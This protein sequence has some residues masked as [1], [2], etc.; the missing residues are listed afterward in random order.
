MDL[1]LGQLKNELQN[2]QDKIDLQKPGSR[3]FELIRLE[4]QK[5]SLEI[6]IEKIKLTEKKTRDF[7]DFER[8]KENSYKSRNPAINILFNLYIDG[9]KY[10]GN[11]KKDPFNLVLNKKGEIEKQTIRKVDK[12]EI[13]SIKAEI[14]TATERVAKIKTT[15]SE[16]K[17][18][19][20][21]VLENRSQI[22]FY[23]KQVQSLKDKLQKKQR[24]F[25]A[26]YYIPLA[27]L[28]SDESKLKIF[29]RDNYVGTKR[30]F[31]TVEENIKIL[32]DLLL[33]DKKTIKLN[34]ISEIKKPLKILTYSWRKKEFAPYGYQVSRGP[35]AMRPFL[36][37]SN[38]TWINSIEELKL[39]IQEK[40]EELKKEKITA[41]S[42]G[43]ATP[44][45]GGGGGPADPPGTPPADPP[46]G[47]PPAP[48]ADQPPGATPPE[49]NSNGE[50]VKT[51]TNAIKLPPENTEEKTKETQKTI[52]KKIRN[53]EIEIEKLLTAHDN[54]VG[55]SIVENIV[56]S[57]L[58][59]INR[60]QGRIYD[61]QSNDYYDK[62]INKN[63]LKPK[64]AL[65]KAVDN[66]YAVSVDLS[67]IGNV[68]IEADNYR[69]QLFSASSYSTRKR[70]Y[71]PYAHK[72]LAYR[73]SI[74]HTWFK[75]YSYYIFSTIPP[76]LT[77]EIKNTKL[78]IQMLSY[79]PTET[80]RNKTI[81]LIREWNK[82]EIIEDFKIV[83]SHHERHLA[84][85]KRLQ[86]DVI[87]RLDMFRPTLNYTILKT[88]LLHTTKCPKHQ[89]R[90]CLTT[91]QRI[92]LVNFNDL[93][94]IENFKTDKVNWDKKNT[95]V[96]S[97][98]EDKTTITVPTFW[99][100][101]FESINING[102]KKPLQDTYTFTIEDFDTSH[103]NDNLT[104][105]MKQ[106]DTLTTKYKTDLN[107]R[108]YLTLYHVLPS[109]CKCNF[110]KIQQLKTRE[111]YIQTKQVY[112]LWVKQTKYIQDEHKKIK[113]LLG[114]TC[115]EQLVKT[116][117]LNDDCLQSLKDLSTRVTSLVTQFVQTVSIAHESVKTLYPEDK[118]PLHYAEL[119]KLHAKYPLFFEAFEK[120]LKI[121]IETIEHISEKDFSYERSVC[122]IDYLTEAYLLLTDVTISLNPNVKLNPL[123]E[124]ILNDTQ[125]YIHHLATLCDILEDRPL[126]GYVYNGNP[127]PIFLETP[128]KEI[129]KTQKE[130][131]EYI[132][133]KTPS[134]SKERQLFCKKY[135][136]MDPQYVLFHSDVRN[137]D[138]SQ[139]IELYNRAKG[140][141][142]QGNFMKCIRCC[143]LLLLFPIN[144]IENDKGTY[145]AIKELLLLL[146]ELT[147]HSN[148][149]LIRSL[150]EIYDTVSRKQVLAQ[151]QFQY[152]Y[153]A[154][155]TKIP[156]LIQQEFGEYTN[157]HKTFGKYILSKFIKYVDDS[158]TNET[159][160]RARRNYMCLQFYLGEIS[161]RQLLTQNRLTKEDY[162]K[163]LHYFPEN[164]VGRLILGN[165]HDA[166]LNT[167]PNKTYEFVAAF[168]EKY[169][170][171]KRFALDH[172]MHVS[173]VQQSEMK[174]EVAVCIR[175]IDIAIKK[176]NYITQIAES[177]KYERED[178]WPKSGIYSTF[179]RATNKPY[180]DGNY[181]I[182]VKVDLALG[183]DGIE[184][185][186]ELD[187]N[188]KTKMLQN[189]SSTLNPF[190]H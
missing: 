116:G 111:N 62:N 47:T 105:A 64:E 73:F 129:Y 152:D 66:Y 165:I 18:Q 86:L 21:T 56:D 52:L 180:V 90:N 41:A 74:F 187:C 107:V 76:L 155:E 166:L 36:K 46:P 156:N 106:L 99:T 172:L 160:V 144:T 136:D 127:I 186:Y 118:Y 16:D 5:N 96:K 48:P 178:N 119:E 42:G 77:N 137:L 115:S 171:E 37:N 161:T 184:N 8:K 188:K 29:E 176:L 25:D 169:Q 19:L 7:E 72:Y 49:Q 128:D 58:T 163:V 79:A 121:L 80:I 170:T 117:D 69:S 78:L 148:T 164:N 108:T 12:S 133:K 141:C 177:S 140:Y 120:V 97:C 14:I 143:F 149:G 113:D 31:L 3:T 93:E 38:L 61:I 82:Y 17:K 26:I 175:D 130:I 142:A 95:L 44:P 13:D 24:L 173:K 88:I 94:Y 145:A 134:T 84:Y 153:Y 91:A 67:Q 15:T 63:L 71:Q 114:K 182:T 179:I 45:T 174:R 151:F 102:I 101:N 103:V 138:L 185:A 190:G 150:P 132:E 10:E 159:Y 40:K 110:D 124:D 32:L 4:G 123:D 54:I 122:Q 39:P 30:S 181:S 22:S 11:E 57:V 189:I 60:V 85:L 104:F 83:Q 20:L 139:F 50:E 100:E 2:V 9:K 1:K 89:L 146:M 33:K 167:D 68:A 70:L 126:R 35:V 59:G 53:I 55:G 27:K 28:N 154:N 65:K 43:P 147:G 98:S 162:T 168:L 51:K 135:A 23:E 158:S 92:I 157:V 34:G 81:E 125:T 6:K 131:V 183:E 75:D 112:N 87:R 109:V